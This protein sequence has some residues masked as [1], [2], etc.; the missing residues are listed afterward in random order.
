MQFLSLSKI[1]ISDTLQIT[2]QHS[3]THSI[4]TILKY[5]VSK[6]QHSNNNHVSGE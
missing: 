5:L 2:R 4:M 3:D 1:Y 6:L